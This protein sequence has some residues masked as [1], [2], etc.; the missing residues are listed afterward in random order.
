MARLAAERLAM[1]ETMVVVRH[2]V[3]RQAVVMR[4][5]AT[6]S[7]CGCVRRREAEAAELR[8]EERLVAV[9]LALLRR[10]H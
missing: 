4:L 7:L 10:R 6:M 8:P 5:A 2:A 1:I 3:V 9:M